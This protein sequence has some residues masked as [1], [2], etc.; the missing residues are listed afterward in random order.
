[1]DKDTRKEWEKLKTA[2]DEYRNNTGFEVAVVSSCIS[3]L[4]RLAQSFIIN[5]PL[6]TRKSYKVH[7]YGEVRHLVNEVVEQQKKTLVTVDVNSE[8]VQKVNGNVENGDSPTK[9]PTNGMKAPPRPRRV[10]V[11]FDINAHSMPNPSHMMP[12]LKPAH[13]M[14]SNNNH[15]IRHVD[16]HQA[17]PAN[18]NPKSF[19]FNKPSRKMNIKPKEKAVKSKPS[20]VDDIELDEFAGFDDDYYNVKSNSKSDDEFEIEPRHDGRYQNLNEAPQIAASMPIKIGGKFEN[21]NT[22]YVI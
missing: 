2:I 14:N 11:G 3:D 13:M 21:F 6:V 17:R 8:K 20:F 7:G 22:T 1:M 12:G 4:D 9:V 18:R 5:S 10:Q 15:H 19:Q 16:N